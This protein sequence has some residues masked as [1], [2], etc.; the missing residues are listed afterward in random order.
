VVNGEERGKKKE[1][2]SVRMRLLFQFTVITRFLSFAPTRPDR[3]D[4]YKSCQP[5]DKSQQKEGKEYALTGMDDD[6]KPGTAKS[7]A[8]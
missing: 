6:P 4:L 2:V 5:K 7:S 3:C 1:A 8:W